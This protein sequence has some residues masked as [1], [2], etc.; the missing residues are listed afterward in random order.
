MAAEPAGPE[1]VLRKGG[2]HGSE[3][4]AYRKKKKK[5]TLAMMGDQLAINRTVKSIVITDTGI[6]PGP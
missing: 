5:N 3:R 1:P 2:G 4:P 6:G